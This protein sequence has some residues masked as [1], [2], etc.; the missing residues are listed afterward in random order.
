MKKQGAVFLICT[1]IL[2]GMGLVCMYSASYPQA[3]DFGRSPDWFLKRQA[4]FALAGLVF[5]LIIC[6]V[7]K[8][9]LT[10]MS[11]PMLIVCAGLMGLTIFTSLGQ[12]TLGARRW[13]TIGPLSLQPSELVKFASVIF[14]ASILN[15]DRKWSLAKRQLIAAAVCLGMGGLILLQKDYSTTVV[16]LAVCVCI[17]M[18][19]GIS[20]PW[21]VLG[22]LF[23]GTGA[24]AVML[25]E[26]YRIKRLAAFVFPDLDPSGI[27]YQVNIAKKAIASGGFWGKGLG[28]GVYKHGIL[29]EVQNDFILAN[30]AEELGLVGIIAVFALFTVF[31][32]LGLRSSRK[33]RETEPFWSYLGFGFTT[34]I[35]LQALVNAAVVSGLFPPTGI[36]LPFFSQ[37]GTNLFVVI[38]EAAFVWRI[39]RIDGGRSG[40][41]REKSEWHDDTVVLP[42][43]LR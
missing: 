28:R 33:L 43:A 8:R 14:L 21:L 10:A 2:V 40:I 9:F 19:S 7:P 26:P 31:A 15:A 6:F 4:I 17:L 24:L 20:V 11:V 16:Y 29:P 42:G 1:L 25:S 34:M 22:F 23:T 38:C 36:P 18:L 27:N 3:R 35:M 13:L 30:V 12:T 32:V 41:A 5:G 39:I 37:G